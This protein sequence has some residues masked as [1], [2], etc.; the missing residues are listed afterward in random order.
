VKSSDV[1]TGI[2]IGA[3]ISA[4]LYPLYGL[5]SQKI[6]RRPTIA[7]I[8]CLNLVP[9]SV[10]YYILVA[11]AYRDPISLVGLVALIV[12]LSF[13]IW[14]VH[15]PYLAESFRTEIRSSGY[16]ISYS[17]AT[18][19]PGLY[20]FYMLGLAK[21][22]PYEFSPIVL[23]ALGGLLL[24]L[25]ALAGPETKDVDLHQGSLSENT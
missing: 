13:P 16:G 1:N 21:L 14:A 23:L 20:S 22:M 2:L 19:V 6:G 4:A 3:A 18:I 17:L 10:L 9:A 15:T 8:G 12:L 25:G 7:V 24:S 5:L 11:G